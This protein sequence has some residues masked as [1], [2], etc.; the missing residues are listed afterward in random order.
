MKQRLLKLFPF[1]RG[2]LNEC[3]ENSSCVL[4]SESVYCFE[5]VFH[6][7]TVYGRKEYLYVS[8]EVKKCLKD[9]WRVFLVLESAGFRIVPD[10]IAKSC[11]IL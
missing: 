5:I 8:F 6:C 10:G 9:C 7:V 4:F 3:A 2:V 11:T 1:Q